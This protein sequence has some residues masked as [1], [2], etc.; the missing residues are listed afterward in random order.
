ML[1]MRPNGLEYFE[2]VK[3]GEIALTSVS[4]QLP[5]VSCHQAKFKARAGNAVPVFIGPSGV[6]I[7]DGATDALTGFQLAA[8][9][10]TGFV[11]VLN[12]NK[13]YGLASAGVGQLTYLAL[14]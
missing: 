10:D 1:G 12:L 14:E 3:T 7:A 8:N 5:N 6:T 4:T 2:T 9:E 11:P 13:F